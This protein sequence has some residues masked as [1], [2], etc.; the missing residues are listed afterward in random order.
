VTISAM[1][2]RRRRASI[3]FGVVTLI[4][5]YALVENVIEKPDGIAISAAFIAG[6]IAVSLISRVS[7][8]TELRVDRIEFDEAARRFITEN[9]ESDGR[10]DI[11]ANKRQAGDR[12]EYESKEDE[13]R[14]LNPVPGS[15]DVLFLEVEVVD[16]SVF[17][18]VLEVRGRKVGRH[19]V[20]RVKSPAVPNAVAAIL[21][22]LRDATGVRPYC[23]F[24][25]SEGNPIAHLLRYLV[26]GQ[27]DTPPVVREIIRQHEP[28]PNRRPGIHVGG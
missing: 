25:W 9:L 17:S 21:L 22:A 3:G 7:R 18:D 15:A 13:Q 16:P 26:L 5:L 8:T 24:E 6:I 23:H 14:A 28:D 19:R 11:V 27:G 1:R 10:L 20:L 12:D 2:H 4:L